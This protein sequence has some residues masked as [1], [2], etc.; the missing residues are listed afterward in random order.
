SLETRPSLRVAVVQTSLARGS[1]EDRSA[2]LR[3]AVEAADTLLARV[4][5]GAV[6]LVVL[7]EGTI[8]FDLAAPEARSARDLLTRHAARIGAPVAVGT[9]GAAPG[10]GSWRNALA[11]VGPDG[12]PEPGY[13]KRRLVPLVERDAL[14]WPALFGAG[15]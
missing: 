6:D 12:G 15:N 8:P 11:V 2:A 3:A 10:A 7:P 14:V 5:A 13:E 1:A 4:P 9:Y